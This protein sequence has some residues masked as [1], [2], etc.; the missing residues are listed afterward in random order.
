MHAMDQ[1]ESFRRIIDAHPTGAPPSEA[2]DEILRILFTGDEIR[3]ALAMSFRLKTVEEI[4]R[5]APVTPEEA[6]RHLEVMAEKGAIFCHPTKRG[7]G[8]ALIP[9]A[10]GLCENSLQ[11]KS[12]NTPSYERL[13]SL[14]KRY[15]NDGMISSICGDPTPLMR[16]IPIESTLP[17]KSHI[18]PYEVVSNLIRSSGTIA[19]SDCAC[20]MIEQ[21]CNAPIETCFDFNNVAEFLIEKSLARR[22]SP[23]EALA[24][25]D[26]TEKAG[27]VH[28]GNNNADKANKICNC[29]ACCCLF[30]RGLTEFNNPHAIATSSYLAFVLEDKCTGCGICSI[31]RCQVKAI[32]PWENK[33]RV[34]AER[35]IGCGLC[36]SACPE[37]SIQLRKREHAPDVPQT[38]KDMGLQVLKEK[39]KL[40]AF[41]EVMMK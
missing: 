7:K 16:I 35:C 28:C 32:N 26:E 25:L 9:T 36:A 4:A 15:R 13:K 29:C 39:G 34:L 6:G 14:W 5:N 17:H 24:I 3:I 30:L 19:V 10:P 21:Y 22:V 8:Y 12:K 23:E 27:L 41:M 1:Y 40:E 31:G 20:R 38:L 18:L 2:L 33:A 11:K 37:G